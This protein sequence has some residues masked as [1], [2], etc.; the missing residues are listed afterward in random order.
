MKP[1]WDQLGDEYAD[2]SSVLIGDSDC[3]DSGKS[4][5]DKFDVKGFP[6]IKYWVDGEVQDYS[7]GRDYDALNEFVSTTLGKLCDVITL[8]D[9]NDKEKGYVEKMKGKGADEREK[10]LVRLTGMK[11]NDMKS[12]LKKWLNKRISLLTAMKEK[13]DEL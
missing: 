10:Q 6:T 2:S 1:A 4:L 12:E 3:T 8:D 5:C 13:N 7:G 11:G 9:C